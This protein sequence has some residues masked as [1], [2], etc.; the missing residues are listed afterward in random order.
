MSTGNLAARHELWFLQQASV[1]AVILE[2]A[3]LVSD[4]A[5]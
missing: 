3:E 5:A 1:I 2:D 4:A